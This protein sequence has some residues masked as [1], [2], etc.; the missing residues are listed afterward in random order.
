MYSSQQYDKGSSEEKN[1]QASIGLERK[2]G[3]E[4]EFM[5]S[6][7]RV[8]KSRVL[9]KQTINSTQEKKNHHHHHPL[10]R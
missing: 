4:K 7:H 2:N 1:T 3:K 8:D 6:I 9:A 5:K 10:Y